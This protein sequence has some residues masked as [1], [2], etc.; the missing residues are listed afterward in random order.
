MLKENAIALVDCN[1]FFVSCE[2]VFDPTLEKR[3]VV[4]LSNNDGCIISRS[5][6]VKALGVKMAEPL[7]KVRGL[8]EKNNTAIL[9]S[10]IE[11]YCEMS[12]RVMEA[13]REDLGQKAVEVYS[14]DEAFI[15]FGTPDKAAEVGTEIKQKI[16]DETGIPVSVGIARTKTLAKLTNRI[17]KTSEKTK[18]VLDLYDS[19]Y[20][21]NA[22][23]KTPVGKI[24]GIGHRNSKKLAEI[25]VKTAFDL[26][27]SS[28]DKICRCLNVFGGRTVLELRGIKCYEIEKTIADKKSIAHTRTFGK[29]ISTYGNLRNAVLNFAARAVER[30]RRDRLAAK[31]VTVF[32]KTDGFKENYFS[33]SK[34]L[35]SIYHSNLQHE[36]NAWVLECFD[37]IFE[38]N[39][40]YKKAGVILG[41]L[42]RADKITN[43]L[44]ENEQFRRWQILADIVDE[45]NFRY[46]RDAVKLANI[47]DLGDGKSSHIYEN[48]NA[49]MPLLTPQ[50]DSNTSEFRRFL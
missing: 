27:N 21:K 7:F 42:V 40:E 32:I 13:A 6:E 46:G 25:N 30:L 26:S 5:D 23:E 49:E 29:S 34:I 9:S 22:L 3:P 47:C 44:F 39:I 12:R 4:V 41:D 16:W 2:R 11:Q 37:Q 38:S 35:N 15:D 45:L 48:G 10:N 24:W 1:N 20:L 19:P 43:R 33:R 50:M 8:L 28:V 17:A 36:I 31:S 18:G 14:I